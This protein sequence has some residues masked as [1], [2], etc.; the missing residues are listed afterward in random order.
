MP[1]WP[2]R[3]RQPFSGLAL[4]A[5]IGIIGADLIP[6]PVWP[7]LALTLL[8]GALAIW[9]KHT[10]LAWLFTAASFYTLHD[11]RHHHSEAH[12]LANELGSNPCVATATGIVW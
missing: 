2:L 7:A 3:P 9:R 5:L 11:L 12:L 1:R 6:A 10:I 4:S 8:A